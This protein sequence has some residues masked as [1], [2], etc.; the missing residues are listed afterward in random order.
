MD[1]KVP[2]V[3]KILVERFE[4]NLSSY[5]SQGWSHEYLLGVLNSR[6]M[7]YYHRKKYLDEFKMR[8]QKILI[9]DCRRL[10]IH[11]I[12]LLNPNHKNHH[13]KMIKLVR[14]MLENTEKIFD[15]KSSNEKQILQRQIDATDKQ[16]DEIVYTLYG[17]T[18]KEITIVEESLLK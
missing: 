17:L 14:I 1:E 6:L 8:F 7:T 16:I 5:K 12:D 11:K 18:K 15:I 9:K 4:K 2:E 3:I 13:D 10:P